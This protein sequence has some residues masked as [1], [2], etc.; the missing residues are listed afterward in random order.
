MAK[1]ELRPVNQ[2]NAAPFCHATISFKLML[3]Y[4]VTQ[5]KPED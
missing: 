5:I 4:G 2:M 1:S 3:I